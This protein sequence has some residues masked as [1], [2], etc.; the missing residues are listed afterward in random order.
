MNI[1]NIKMNDEAR[2]AIDG[3]VAAS[4]GKLSVNDVLCSALTLKYGFECAP[5]KKLKYFQVCNGRPQNLQRLLEAHPLFERLSIED[6]DEAFEAA[7]KIAA[8][9]GCEQS[10][11][12]EYFWSRISPYD[13]TTQRDITPSRKSIFELIS[14]ENQARG[15]NIAFVRSSALMKA[16]RKIY[17]K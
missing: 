7:E 5:V 4:K 14:H 8:D 13:S 9:L 12:E 16:G 17:G 6:R 15:G 10:E 1:T 3:E 2:A 11:A